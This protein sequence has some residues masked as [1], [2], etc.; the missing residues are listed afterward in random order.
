MPKKNA[1]LKRKLLKEVN[2]NIS[3]L[4]LISVVAIVLFLFLYTSEKTGRSAA[5]VSWTIYIHFVLN[6][7][8]VVKRS[9]I[10]FRKEY[11]ET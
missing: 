4:I 10:L 5:A 8:M 11:D 7:L 3:Y 9:H 1:D 6:L 2:S